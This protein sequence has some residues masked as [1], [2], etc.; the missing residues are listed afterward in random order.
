VSVIWN[1][2]HLTDSNKIEN[3]QRKLQISVVIVSF[4]LIFYV[5]LA[6]VAASKVIL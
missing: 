1:N 2:L 5:I 3:I 6:V 4:R